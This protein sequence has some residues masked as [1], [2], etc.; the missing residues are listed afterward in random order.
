AGGR[1]GGARSWRSRGRKGCGNPGA[2]PL[3]RRLRSPTGGPDAGRWGEARRTATARSRRTAGDEG[4]PGM[5]MHH[6]GV[7]SDAGLVG[8]LWPEQSPPLADL[9]VTEVRSTGTVNAIYRLG[10]RLC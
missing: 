9:P 8:R 10:D 1:V 5:E 2:P 3:R 6:D 4:S 7:D